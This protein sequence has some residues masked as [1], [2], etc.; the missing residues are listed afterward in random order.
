MKR[1]PDEE[2]KRWWLQGLRDYDDA[3]F[4]KDGERFNL[5]CFLAQQSAEKAL[6][7]FLYL[8]GEQDV[9]GH[10][11]A[12]LA[13]MATEIDGQ[14]REVFRKAAVLDK[15]YIPTRYP[16]GLPGGIPADAFDAADAERALS[17]AK[18]V[19]EFIRQKLQQ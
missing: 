2:A 14:F 16:N 11:V 7:A 9:R 1:R 4:C 6:K 3:V 18:T 12:E 10:S 8:K 5:S 19:L 13:R 15:Y 17:L